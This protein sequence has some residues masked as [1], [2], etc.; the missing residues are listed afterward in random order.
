MATHYYTG[1]PA[2]RGTFHPSSTALE[3]FTPA[4][5]IE[6][7]SASGN[8][9][10]SDLA[11]LNRFQYSQ[12]T[13]DANQ[14][15]I[16]VEMQEM[17]VPEAAAAWME[18]KRVYM[19]E[20]TVSCYESHFKALF[21]VFGQIKLQDIT[22]N[23][24]RTY[25]AMRSTNAD[26][27]WART[28]GPSCI[29]HEL[30]TLSQILRHA[31]LW[32]GLADFYQPLKLGRWTPPRVMS[33]ADEGKLF[34]LA[35]RNPKWELAFIA[36]GLTLNTTAS[37]CELRGL[38]RKHF[39]MTAERSDVYIPSDVVKNEYRAR[40]IPL[41]PTAKKLA[42]R[43]LDRAASLGSKDPEH[44]VFPFREKRN[45][46]DP[47][48]P[49]SSSW[50]RKQFE[51]LRVAAELPWLRPHD[52]RHQAITKFLENG[53]AEETV[54][55][56]A[57]HVSNQMLKHYSHPRIEAKYDA[58]LALEYGRTYGIS[59]NVQRARFA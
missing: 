41:N 30:N 52:L 12:P 33:P 28:A 50:M 18:W 7:P 39:V 58:V 37:G 19:K 44:Y 42:Q 53:S 6:M 5:T 55:A 16:G 23:H 14:F 11:S 45:N 9:A 47:T 31:K 24:L 46:F 54:M 29:N 49:A 25:Q 59:Q 36:V 51:E 27:I 26:S 10:F 4:Q 38:Q 3:P 56:I 15:A 21:K 13:M 17:L 43:A 57:G 35:M 1:A 48:R 2:L 32:V 34:L 40:R 8:F 20:K 22:P